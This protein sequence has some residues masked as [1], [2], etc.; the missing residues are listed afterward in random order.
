MVLV[1]PDALLSLWLATLLPVSFSP[2]RQAQAQASS[3]EHSLL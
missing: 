1:K 2:F 3:W